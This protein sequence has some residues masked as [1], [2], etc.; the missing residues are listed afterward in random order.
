MTA[1]RY[2]KRIESVHVESI[3]GDLCVYDTARQHVHA[4]NHTAAFVWQ[5][6]DGRTAP[7]ELA[8]ALS[9]ETSV[10]NAEALVRLT[11]QEL[12]AAQLLAAPIDEV[13]Q[14]SRRD[15]LRRGVA[16]AAIPAIYSIVAPTPAAAQSAAASDADERLAKSRHPGRH[17]GGHADR[18][19]LRRRRHGGGRRRWRRDG[20]QRRSGQH[21][22][23]DCQLCGRWGGRVG[24]PHGDGHDG[25][26]DQR[27]ANLH[28]QSRFHD[29]Q[30]YRQSGDLYCARP[31]SSASRFWPPARRAASGLGL[32][33]AR[34]AWAVGRRRPC[35]SRRA[36]P[37]PCVSVAS[38]QM[39]LP[40]RLRR[41]VVSTAAAEAP[42]TQAGAAA[43][44]VCVMAPPR[45]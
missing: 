42:E 15:L 20:H 44:R 3:D 11:L 40:P 6:C 25:W 22:V 43:P 33:A 34:V 1:G 17:V 18:H 13:A 2:P 4:L 28:D 36:R 7:A 12:A 19:Q 21:D 24:C 26:R 45:S 5:R 39:V 23:A 31:A 32:S 41:P 16:A 14:V 10:D 29:V 35:P 9:A 37:S 27:R 8:A 38:A 30:L